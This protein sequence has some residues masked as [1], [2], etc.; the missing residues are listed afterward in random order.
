MRS[1]CLL[2]QGE[3][4]TTFNPI[5]FVAP[6]RPSYPNASLHG[7]YDRAHD[8]RRG[9]ASGREIHGAADGLPVLARR[10]GRLL[11]HEQRE[12]LAGRGA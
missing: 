7:P 6:E 10:S 8:A 4:R 9:L 5:H 12:L 11:A 1:S 2:R 3:R